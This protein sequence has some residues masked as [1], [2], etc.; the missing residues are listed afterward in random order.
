MQVLCSLSWLNIPVRELI[1]KPAVII[2]LLCVEDGDVMMV[3]ILYITQCCWRVSLSL[4]LSAF[5]SVLWKVLLSV[6]PRL[7]PT[8]TVNYQRWQRSFS[9]SNYHPH[10]TASL[11]RPAVPH[12]EV[13]GGCSVGTSWG[14]REMQAD[15]FVLQAHY[16]D[17]P[18]SDHAVFSVGS[19]SCLPM[20]NK[21]FSLAINK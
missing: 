14:G 19:D 3:V 10:S 1:L 18:Q 7:T 12:P 20:T 13:Q 21:L 16:T 4:P 17:I 8:E 9:L 11:Q 2:D 6:G 15:D 5:F